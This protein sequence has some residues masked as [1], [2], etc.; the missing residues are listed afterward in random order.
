MREDF[1]H[2]VWR[3]QH[4]LRT[5]LQTTGGEPVSIVEVGEPN[6]HGGP[7]FL[8][9]RIRIDGTL[10]AGHVEI[11]ILASEWRLHGHGTD[12][13]YDNVI[14]HVV[15]EEDCAIFRAN[16]ERLPCLV[17]Q[18]R[19]PPGIQASYYRMLQEKAWIP[20]QTQWRNTGETVKQ[21]W[22]ERMS[23]ERLEQQTIRLKGMLE[24]F[25]GDWDEA[26]FC[27]IARNLG[28]PV[29]AGA[30]EALA[31]CT[32]WKLLLRKRGFPE[33][34]EAL[35]FGQAGML[36]E[37]FEEDYPR[38]LQQEYRFL[39]EQYDLI[40]LRGAI[41]KFMRMRPANFPTVRIAQLARLV[42]QGEDLF[43]KAMAAAGPGEWERMFEVEV[44]Q[45]WRTHYTFGQISP[46][47]NKSLGKTAVHG[48]LINAVAP[49]LFL[50]GTVLHSPR[51][52]DKAV[53]LLQALP[54]ED[55]HITRKWTELGMRPL[56]A[57]QSQGLFQ[58]K[59]GYCDGYKC[60]ECAIG[61]DILKNA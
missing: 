50:Y 48:L 29:N 18:R 58:L 3:Y 56:N 30:L 27:M 28:H 23:V 49:F 57:A 1:L 37:I 9:A 8:N 61:H 4:F 36:E 31:R 59:T 32:P 16:G 39:Q 60:L 26:F 54:A 11:H 17:L 45:Y 34:L 7:D 47:R 44:S 35:L 22:L 19:I 25:G 51:H 42:Y 33:M 52:C 14:L 24:G 41:W 40:P 15:L 2:Y 20:C 6:P 38:R 55:N 53:Q 46:P 43:D 21:L 13:A 5:D 12:Q 10:W